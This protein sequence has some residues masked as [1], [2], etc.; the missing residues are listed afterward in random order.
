MHQIKKIKG[1]GKSTI[2]FT[3]TEKV[4]N[5]LQNSSIISK[6][7]FQQ[8]RNSR[9]FSLS[10]KSH[11]LQKS[12]FIC[13]HVKNLHTERWN[14]KNFPKIR[15]NRTMSMPIN[16]IQHLIMKK[17][18]AKALEFKNAKKP[19]FVVLKIIHSYKERDLP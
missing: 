4:F 7:N 12:Y 5:K 8:I 17:C 15:N 3:D 18:L 11:L 19:F 9:E 1:G 2:I 6:W 13:F 14:I 16:S 10:E